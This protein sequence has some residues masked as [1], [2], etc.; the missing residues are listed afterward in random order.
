MRSNISNGGSIVKK[1]IQNINADWKFLID[2]SDQ[3]REKGYFSPDYDDS[4]WMNT[5]VPSCFE[6]IDPGF[7]RYKGSGWYRKT[8]EINQIGS[9]TVLKFD[10]VNFNCVVWLNGKMVGFHNYGFLPF[11]IDISKAVI[12][13][14]NTLAVGVDNKMAG[15]QLPT[16]HGWRNQAGILRDVHIIYRPDAYIDLMH[17]HT[18]L[19]GDIN[20][21]LE[22]VNTSKSPIECDLILDIDKKSDVIKKLKIEHGCNKIDV[23][24][25]IEGVKFWDID[26]PNLYTLTAVLAGENIEDKVEQKFGVRTIRVKNGHI[27]LNDNPIFLKGFNRHEDCPET[28]M[29]LNREMT[30][31]DYEDIK[32]LGANFMRLCHYPHSTYELELCDEIGLLVLDEIPLNGTMVVLPDTIEYDGH[33]TKK[34]YEDIYLNSLEYLKRLIRRD[35]NHPSVI[36]WSVSNENDETVESIRNIISSLQEYACQMDS[37]RLVTH[38]AYQTAW[39]NNDIM[40]ETFN[41]A[42]VV[43]MNAYPG[44]G[45]LHSKRP[46]DLDYADIFYKKLSDRIKI[47]YPQKPIVITEYGSVSDLAIRGIKSNEYMADIIMAEMEAIRKYYDGG[48]IWC[49]ADHAWEVLFDNVNSSVA[50]LYGVFGR[51]TSPYGVYYRNRIPKDV[52]GRLKS[53]WEIKTDFEKNGGLY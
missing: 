15:G 14:E 24:L 40:A 47:I 33:I 35:F 12:K 4:L 9:T 10:A 38:V 8:L 23:C 6:S 5:Y 43:C 20:V 41:N 7:I 52:V 46:L 31:K 34:S 11:E 30:K 16:F 45:I 18:Y 21:C 44:M 36:I 28:G 19:S 32:A 49:Y 39:E 42:D 25:K 2:P 53:G 17:I 51:L 37:S 48:S 29:A 26:S 1:T 50:Y 13:G 3:G 27:E 22:I